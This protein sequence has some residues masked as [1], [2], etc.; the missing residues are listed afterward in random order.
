MAF[1]FGVYRLHVVDVQVVVSMFQILFRH[2]FDCVVRHLALLALRFCYCLGFFDACV[3]FTLPPL[4]PPR[5]IHDTRAAVTRRAVVPQ[6]GFRPEIIL[7]FGFNRCRF[8]GFWQMSVS[9]IF[10]SC[11]FLGFLTDVG[12]WDFDRCQFLGFSIIHRY[13][14]HQS[15][16]FWLSVHVPLWGMSPQFLG[17]LTVCYTQVAS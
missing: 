8:L 1:S 13:S 12:F 9:G 15:V 4:P 10:N 16:L 14:V 17:F 11:R 6:S 7:T 2:C 5:L 3:A